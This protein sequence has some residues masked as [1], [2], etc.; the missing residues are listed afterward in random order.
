[1]TQQETNKSL[2]R[3]ALAQI[4]QGV[5]ALLE[6]HAAP[7]FRM[8]SGQQPPMD[9]AAFKGFCAMFSAAFPGFRH[10]LEDLIAE[11]DKVVRAGTF[12]GTHKGEFMGVPASGKSVAMAFA[13]VDAYQGGK[14]KSIR[15]NADFMGLMQQIGA[16][17]APAHV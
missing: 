4:D 1:M 3:R 8:Y 11:G 9:L 6:E 15:I 14:L 5:F 10:E 13:S 2:S 7:D 17:P 12:Y 16:I